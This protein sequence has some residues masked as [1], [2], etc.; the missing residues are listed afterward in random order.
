MAG[1]SETRH[2]KV[3]LASQKRSTLV[4]TPAGDAVGFDGGNLQ[5]ELRIL[6]SLLDGTDLKNVAV[7]LGGANYFGTI[8]IGG[9]TSLGQKAE[10]V[11]GRL[12]ICNASEEMQNIMRVMHLEERCPHFKT[13]RDALK[14]LK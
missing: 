3:L 5:D 11:G 13:L 7:D 14:E 6:I 1:I 10:E 12:V 2:N 4:V 9:I 8:V